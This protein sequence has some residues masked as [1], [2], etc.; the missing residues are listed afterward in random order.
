M[1]FLNC[2]GV[3]GAAGVSGADWSVIET[4]KQNIEE[5][6]PYYN[7]ETEDSIPVPQYEDVKPGFYLYVMTMTIIETK[8]LAQIDVKD[9]DSV[10]N[11]L[12]E[13]ISADTASE[14]EIK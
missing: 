2:E 3:A 11:N 1:R 4:E 10:S 8:E 13:K 6:N 14:D 12:A 9:T 7:K 5:K